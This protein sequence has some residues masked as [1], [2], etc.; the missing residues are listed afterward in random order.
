M[1]YS[2][3]PS[4]IIA[5]L[6]SYALSSNVPPQTNICPS[7]ISYCY[8]NFTEYIAKPLGIDAIGNENI[9]YCHIKNT[10]KLYNFKMNVLFSMNGGTKKRR[11]N[12]LKLLNNNQ[13]IEKTSSSTSVTELG[14]NIC[15]INYCDIQLK[16]IKNKYKKGS[17]F[18][19]KL[20]EINKSKVFFG[21]MAV[22]YLFSVSIVVYYKV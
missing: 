16:N 4:L 20:E 8:G 7:N 3:F 17:E 9:T 18:K 15:D 6:V 2:Q 14:I 10:L 1:T 5:G 12:S 22:I 19:K 21:Y 13:Y 11:R